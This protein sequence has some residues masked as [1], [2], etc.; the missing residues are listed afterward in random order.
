MRLEHGGELITTTALGL[1]AAFIGGLLTLLILVFR[2]SPLATIHGQN[3][4]LRHLSDETTGI[5]YGIALG[6]AGLLVFPT[7]PLVVA[8]L[9]RLAGN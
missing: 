5:P 3:M 4:F 1:T 2:K 6:A 8:A 9:E 7:S